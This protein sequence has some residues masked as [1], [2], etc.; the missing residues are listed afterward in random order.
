MFDRQ[1][2]AV[3]AS[4]VTGSNNTRSSEIVAGGFTNRGMLSIGHFKES[5]DGFRENNNSDQSISN[6]FGQIR[7]NSQLNLQ[8]E[9]KQRDWEF[10]DLAQYFNHEYKNVTRTIDSDM[11]RVGVN[12]SPSPTSAYLLSA[13][14]LDSED[15]DDTDNGGDV[16]TGDFEETL[17]E[18][19][20]I[21]S[22]KRV[23]LVSGFGFQDSDIE[24]N[25]SFL[26]YGNLIEIDP[27][28]KDLDSNRGYLYTHIPWS[29][30]TAILGVEYASIDDNDLLDKDQTN[31]KLGLIWDISQTSTLR[32][33]AFRTI[34][35]SSAI[36]QTISP[37]QVAGF[38]QLFDDSIGSDAWRYGVGWDSKILA[39]LY[40]GIELSRRTITDISQTLEEERTLVEIDYKQQYHSAYLSWPFLD[41]YSIGSQFSYDD[42]K[43]DFVEGD[44]NPGKP[45]EMNT[46]TFSVMAK[47][48]HPLGF[49]GEIEAFHVSQ[50]IDFVLQ[51]GGTEEQND[52]FWLGNISIGMRL[53]KKIGLV[54]MEVRNIFDRDFNFQSIDPG[55]GTTQAIQH[56]PERFMMLRAELWYD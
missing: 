39:N 4:G 23:S 31:P 51:S 15:T 5:T 9:A 20:Y 17:T 27:I 47:Y 10:G 7:I 22:G 38:N 29:D 50:A 18:G 40:G 41:R 37:T 36:K 13:I 6:V 28:I 14:H 49:Y 24:F 35:V 8:A 42:F 1:H 16:L 26:F 3:L 46:K 52:S 12:F 56:Y 32:L 55:T 19:Q 44:A 43:R 30:M 48:H 11:Y 45:A 54:E 25:N 21:Y 2:L 33:A 34:Q 53:P